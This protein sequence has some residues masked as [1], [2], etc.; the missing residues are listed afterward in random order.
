QRH[1]DPGQP[2]P[3]ATVAG[4]SPCPLPDEALLRE[5][6]PP[7]LRRPRD[8][9]ART[10]RLGE[11]RAD[12]GRRLWPEARAAFTAAGRLTPALPEAWLGV[13][14]AYLAEERWSEAAR[15][16]RALVETFPWSFAARLGLGR[17]LAEEGHL[18][19]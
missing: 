19:E 1:L 3:Y 13:G 18:S 7:R 11:G 8:P 12:L 17:A 14:D 6:E 5:G 10:L 9:A 2:F 16:Y 4:R 15:V